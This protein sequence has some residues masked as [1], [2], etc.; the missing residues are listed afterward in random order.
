MNIL[1]ISRLLMDD[2]TNKILIQTSEGA[3]SAAQ[4]SNDSG[5]PLETCYKKMMLL[6]EMGLVKRVAMCARG[7]SQRT[8][9]FISELKEVHI[10]YYKGKIRVKLEFLTGGEEEFVKRLVTA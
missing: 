3:K 2:Q 8:G 6:E 4:I 1:D 5:I 9:F 10:F 7:S